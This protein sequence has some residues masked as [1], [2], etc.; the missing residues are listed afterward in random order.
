VNSRPGPL[1]RLLP[2]GEEQARWRPSARVLCLGNELVADD[3]LGSAVAAPLRRLTLPGV[4]VVDTSVTGFQLLDHILNVR[5]LLV[6]DTIL[7]G[8]ADPGTVFLLR[9]EDVRA[10]P[11]SSPHYIGLFEALAVGR[12]LDLAVPEEVAI[13]A[14][15]AAD[16]Y[17]VGGRMH[18][19]VDKAIPDVLKL[20]S[21]FLASRLP[22]APG[23]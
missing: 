15:E 1:S 11:G 9:E 16:C 17:T 8:T 18:P 2:P 6:I 5:R 12:K 23:E 21:K 10:V 4:D 20:I 13:I 19:S 14:V 22:T 7:T 3:A